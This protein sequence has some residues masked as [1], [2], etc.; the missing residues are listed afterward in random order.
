MTG[1]RYKDSDTAIHRLNPFCKLLW[2]AN[3]LIFALI[4]DNPV[5][6]VA[7]FLATLPVVAAAR[8]WKEWLSVMKF[9]LYLG[10]AIVIINML[11]SYHGAHILFEAPF[12]LP[13]VG[14]PTLTLEAAF[15]GVVMS[16]RLALIISAFALL[17]LTVHPDDLLLAMIKMKLP[18]K[19]VLVTS[20]STRFIPALV[21]DAQCLS[22]VQRSR[23]LELDKGNLVQ[24]IRSRMAIVIPLL[25]NSLDRTVQVAEA[26]EARA[27]GSGGKRTFYKPIRFTGRDALALTLGSLAAAL[28]ISMRLG[29]YGDYQYY[30]TLGGIG[31][32]ALEW[33][34]LGLLV[35]LLLSGVFVAAGGREAGLD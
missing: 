27:F 20:L 26:M 3:I 9:T 28:G 25:S 1:F 29:G 18:Y 2:M 13:V 10:I 7:L 6:L 5:Y 8:I 11:V 4:F 17:T 16:L 33:S 21:E 30:P 22:D 31:G 14:V 32:S 15:F 19:S 23:G 35:L 24:K 12:R 34:V